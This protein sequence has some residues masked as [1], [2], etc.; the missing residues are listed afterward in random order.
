M[1]Y[2]YYIGGSLV[3]APHYGSKLFASPMKE[4]NEQ[5]VM[6]E[7]CEENK[8]DSYR[9][10]TKYDDKVDRYYSSYDLGVLIQNKESYL[11]GKI[12]S[13][14]DVD[15]YSFYYGQR[16]F[17]SKMGISSSLTIRLEIPQGSDYD[18]TVYDSEG[19]QIGMAKT[20]PDGS[21]ELTLPDWDNRTTR[22]T[23]KV[24]N[25]NGD[26]EVNTTEPYRISIREKKTPASS[27]YQNTS[28]QEEVERLHKE[29]YASLSETERYQGNQTVEEL[30]NK[31][32]SGESLSSQEE[33]YLK[34]FSNLH[35]YEK[36][37][38]LGKIRS[39]LYPKIQESIE[40]AG[41][42]LQGKDWSF[43]L[44]MHGKITIFG[45]FSEEEKQVIAD[46]LQSNY[47]T[48]LWDSYMQA[49]EIGT[50]K[51]NHVSAYKEVADFL[52]KSTNGQY[53]WNHISVD[54]NGIISGL[55]EKM[56]Q[57]LNSQESNGKYEQLRD[58]IYMLWDY[59]NKY[60]IHTLETF[61]AQYKMQGEQI[62]IL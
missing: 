4:M 47:G 38:A 9:Q 57:L 41:I 25:H 22:Y 1:N 46:T 11:E 16:G 26:G 55:P 60:G 39:E 12:N 31:M 20:N 51:Y 24:E 59:Q 27:E 15:Y 10:K 37:A 43:E 52:E 2:S 56:C 42:E 44:D 36:A 54:Q 48:D 49:A 3:D 14:D 53:T 62:E 45:D 50:E 40:V 30:L 13:E 61:K 32:A 6:V 18:L 7:N 29:Q 23:I 17:Y 8:N 5:T 35:D 58:D 19:N 28:Y 34:I 21:K 33:T